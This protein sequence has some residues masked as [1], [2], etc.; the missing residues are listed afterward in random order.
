MSQLPLQSATAK[1]YLPDSVGSQVR[2]G[3]HAYRVPLV[4]VA[5]EFDSRTTAVVAIAMVEAALPEPM[6]D[7]SATTLTTSHRLQVPPGGAHRPDEL[8]ALAA[9]A[10]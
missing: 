4:A 9:I 1:L 7:I 8:H 10:V 3:V 2:E 6:H 5:L